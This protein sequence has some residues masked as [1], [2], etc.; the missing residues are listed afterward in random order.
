MNNDDSAKL[1]TFDI[2]RKRAGIAAK[3]GATAFIIYSKS[4]AGDI[5]YN[6]FDMAQT[7]DI[8]V[9]FIKSK[10]FKKYAADESSILDVKLNVDL[11]PKSRNGNNVIGFAD[12]GADSTIVTSAHLGAETGVAA[13]IE[14]AR[15]MKASKAKN[16]NYLYIAYCGE[17]DGA[18]GQ[19]YF[20]N[21]LPGG[22]KNISRTVNMDSLAATVEE[23]KELNLVKRSVEIIKK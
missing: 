15:L 11:Q 6:R 7:V 17:K 12:N 20:N 2:I 13:L 5:E 4:A 23:P 1:D 22:V 8:P 3:K 21:H 16:A 19:E 14:T 10:A 18:Q 9:L